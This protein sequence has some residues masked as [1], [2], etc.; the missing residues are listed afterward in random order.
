MALRNSLELGGPETARLLQWSSCTPASLLTVWPENVGGARRRGRR[1]GKWQRKRNRWSFTPGQALRKW[2]LEFR[3]SCKAVCGPRAPSSR[4]LL[5]LGRIELRVS[6]PW[7]QG[8][9]IRVLTRVERENV[10]GVRAGSGW[11]G[12][13]EVNARP[14]EI[15]PRCMIV[16]RCK[17]CPV[18]NTAHVSHPGIMFFC[19]SVSSSTCSFLSIHSKKTQRIFSR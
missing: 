1:E 12:W 19:C 11:A 6:S 17:W 4:G 14:S 15:C 7:G 5:G 9:R 2:G 8:R 10:M 16:C 13:W 3:A 18:S